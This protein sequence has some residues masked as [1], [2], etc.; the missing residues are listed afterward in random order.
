MKTINPQI[1]ECQQPQ[2]QDTETKVSQNVTAKLLKTTD[3]EKILNLKN[4]N[5]FKKAPYLQTIKI[6]QQISCWK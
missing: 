1:P 6:M 4:S 5:V 3:K 2:S